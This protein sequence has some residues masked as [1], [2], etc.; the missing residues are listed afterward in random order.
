[1]ITFDSQ[2][3]SGDEGGG[4]PQLIWGEGDWNVRAGHAGGVNGEQLQERQGWLQ[5]GFRSLIVKDN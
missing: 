3:M 5:L 1:M 4:N 2:K